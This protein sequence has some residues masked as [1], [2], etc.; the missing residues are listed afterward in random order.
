MKRISW[1][2]S[3]ISNNINQIAKYFNTGGLHSQTVTAE[4]GKALDAV[5]Q[6]QVDVTRIINYFYLSIQ[7]I[8]RMPTGSNCFIDD[9]ELLVCEQLDFLYRLPM[10]AAIISSVV[11]FI[12]SLSFSPNY[13][14]YPF[15]R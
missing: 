11:G 5:L 12:T 15:S 4:L 6:I 10:P 8:K 13:F 14:K 2:L 7:R 3:N 9:V 1:L